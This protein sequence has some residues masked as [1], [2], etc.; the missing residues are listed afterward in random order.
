MIKVKQWIITPRF[1]YCIE[2]DLP[3]I[4]A[5]CPC[6]GGEGTTVNPSIDGNGLTGED[7]E[8]LGPD[9]RES[10]LAGDYDVRC[11][12]CNGNRVLD[13]LD[14]ERLSPKLQE[15]VQEYIDEERASEAE[16][17]ADRRWGA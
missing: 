7:M 5:V 2:V 9:F 6:C 16:R 4:K 8:E 14:W 3:A 1:K 17:A 13:I 15:A 12:E 11:P 10:Y